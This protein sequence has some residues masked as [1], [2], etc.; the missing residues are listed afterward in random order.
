MR[1]QQL[2]LQQLVHEGFIKHGANDVIHNYWKRTGMET[3]LV[4]TGQR[5]GSATL[6]LRP[7][8]GDMELHGTDQ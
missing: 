3:W 4:M 2:W 1:V 5:V 6:K 8:E 7:T